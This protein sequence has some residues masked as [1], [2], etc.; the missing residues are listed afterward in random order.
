MSGRH[1]TIFK[2]ALRQV[3]VLFSK[4]LSRLEEAGSTRTYRDVFRVCEL[5]NIDYVVLRYLN[6]GASPFEEWAEE[7]LHNGE[8]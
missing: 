1:L 7:W 5:E 3:V 6:T 8:V 2:Y 4:L